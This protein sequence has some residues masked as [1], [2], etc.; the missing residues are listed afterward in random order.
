MRRRIGKLCA[1][2]AWF[3][4]GLGLTNIAWFAFDSRQC[5]LRSTIAIPD[6]CVQDY[7]IPPPLSKKRCSD[8]HVH[9]LRSTIA[10]P[11]LASVHCNKYHS[12]FKKSCGD[13]LVGTTSGVWRRIYENSAW[14]W[15]KRAFEKEGRI[16]R[17]DMI[18]V[19]Y[20]PEENNARLR[21]RYIVLLCKYASRWTGH[22]NKND[23]ECVLKQCNV[24]LV[25]MFSR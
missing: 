12:Q 10:I 3:R 11:S 6:N 14:S 2:R 19:E 13:L 24:H 16:G 8:S 25:D 21:L 18:R 23:S 4:K 5:S 17:Y 20:F 15:R 7:H 9:S 1:M 22:F